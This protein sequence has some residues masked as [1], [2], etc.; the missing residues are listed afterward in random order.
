[1]NNID[2]KKYFLKT[3]VVALCIS[4]LIG[5]IIFLFGDL[6]EI[7]AQLLM[8]TLTFGGFSLTGLCSARIQNKNHLK[9]FSII[10]MVIA[11]LGF[12]ITI[13]VIWEFDH[14]ES[15]WKGMTVFIIL[16]IAIAHAS[17]LLQISPKTNKI[18]YLLIGTIVFISL[19]A[20]MLIISVIT[21]FSESEFYFRLLG[22]FSILD[23]LG[24]IATPIMNKITEKTE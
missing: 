8:T 24:T 3:L 10:G 13:S 12:L 15:I 11:V 9:N 1:M 16:S 23:V 17:L 22:V 20:L 21:E 19:V 6:G 2:F 7:E 4:A 5:I 14:I 18:K